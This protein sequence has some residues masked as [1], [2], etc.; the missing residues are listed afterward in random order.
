MPKIEIG[1]RIDITGFLESFSSEP[2]F[3][4]LLTSWKSISP[5]KQELIEQHLMHFVQIEL[6]KPPSQ[7]ARPRVGFLGHD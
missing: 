4:A 6:P 1:G 5:D 2:L 7:S 3:D